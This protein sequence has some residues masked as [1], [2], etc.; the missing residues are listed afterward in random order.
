MIL[1]GVF[2]KVLIVLDSLEAACCDASCSGAFAA[3]FKTSVEG[4]YPDLRSDAVD[5]LDQCGNIDPQPVLE[6]SAREVVESAA[7]LFGSEA[8]RLLTRCAFGAGPR[9]EYRDLVVRQIRAGKVALMRHAKAAAS[10]FTIG[11]K[12]KD[13]LSENMERP[14]YHGGSRA[15]T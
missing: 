8:S 2:E 14:D 13:T 7:L 9:T 4:R 11:K 10:T 15:S 6:P 12:G 1:R 3:L 5:L